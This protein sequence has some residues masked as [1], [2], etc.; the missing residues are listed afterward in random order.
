MGIACFDDC[1]FLGAGHYPQCTARVAHYFNHFHALNLLAGGAISYAVGDAPARIVEAPALYWTWPGVLYRYH[2]APG[3]RWHHY[4][5]SFTGPRVRSWIQGGLFPLV[6]W[7]LV[8]PGDGRGSHQAM[9]RLVELVHQADPREQMQRVHLL[10]GLLA[11]CATGLQQTGAGGLPQ[12]IQDLAARIHRHPMQEWDQERLAQEA[13]VSADHFRRSFARHAGRPLYRFV[14]EARLDAAAR[15]LVGSE[16]GITLIARR[17]GFSDTSHFTRR[18]RRHT[19]ST[20]AVYRAE[21]SMP[22]R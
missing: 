20:P 14:L 12:H 2:A 17:Y 4:W 7:P 16:V 3:R 13:G 10:E 19:G 18:F 8:Q 15:D 11:R 22:R 5:V 1:R 21:L 6:A 9:A